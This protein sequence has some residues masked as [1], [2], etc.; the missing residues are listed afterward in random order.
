MPEKKTAT[1]SAEPAKAKSQAA[2]RDSGSRRRTTQASAGCYR[3]LGL[4]VNAPFDQVVAAHRKLRRQHQRAG[5]VRLGEVARIDSAFREIRKFHYRKAKSHRKRQARRIRV[6]RAFIRQTAMVACLV[7][8][9]ILL[10]APTLSDYR[11]EATEVAIGDVLYSQSES[12]HFGVVIGHD[13]AHSFRSGP[14]VESYR[15]RLAETDEAV[16][17]SRHTLI[18][19]MHVRTPASRAS[20]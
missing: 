4:P 12:K 16:W 15:V 9:T 11:L 13:P 18:R 20:K 10:G 1:H 6:R 8:S 7:I 17:I 19:T 3:A 5:G 14:P 2:R